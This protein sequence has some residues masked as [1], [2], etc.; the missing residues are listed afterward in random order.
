MT[1][2][3]NHIAYPDAYITLQQD[4]GKWKLVPSK[5]PSSLHASRED[6]YDELK[7]I[8]EKSCGGDEGCLMC[9]GWSS[10]LRVP[11]LKTTTGPTGCH[12]E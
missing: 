2:I 11:P 6:A 4:S 7:E 1:P 8:R 9:S 5:G 12:K 10:S 3:D